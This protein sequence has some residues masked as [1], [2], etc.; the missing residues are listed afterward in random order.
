MSIIVEHLTHIYSKNTP[1]ERAAIRDV[2]FSI[3]DGEFVGLIGHTGSGKSTLIEH[4]NG[5]LKPDSGHIYIDGT[6]IT[7]S[8]CNLSEI[9][10][11]VGLVFQY[12]EYQLFEETVFK[13]IAYGP[14]N[15][16]LTKEE[17]RARV[18]DAA[19][20]VGLSPDVMDKS[21]FELSGGQKR[22]VAIAGILAM[23]PKVLIL[24]EPTAGLD[25]AGRNDLIERLKQLHREKKITI[26][27]VT[28][29]MEDIAGMAQKILVMSKG[30][31]VCDGT[32]NDVFSK[33]KY[34]KSIGLD[35][36]QICT[37]MEYFQEH[38]DSSI[39]T[40]IY[41]VKKAADVIFEAIKGAKN[42]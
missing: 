23:E 35:I 29:S 40:E 11:K 13:D 34:L 14:S 12:P 4:L 30:S 33:G 42:A 26:I 27:V 16:G 21:P 20:F 3:D 39:S 15:L 38:L 36:P 18:F 6:D 41:D 24:D 25:P 32:I 31:L 17:I 5:L 8:G 22:R 1:F 9:R 19:K 10:S 2:S 7:A 28:H 37:V